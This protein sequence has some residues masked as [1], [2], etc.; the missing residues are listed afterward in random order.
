MNPAMG[1]IMIAV[2]KRLIG[3]PII[4]YAQKWPT[5]RSSYSAKKY[6]AMQKTA[7]VKSHN[8]NFQ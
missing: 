2:T 6:I 3:M 8:F 7:D 1:A 4:R 5:D